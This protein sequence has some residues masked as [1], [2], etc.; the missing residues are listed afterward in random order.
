MG[1][2]RFSGIPGRR[3]RAVVL[4]DIFPKCIFISLFIIFAA[5]CF[6]LA[7]C[8]DDEIVA[9]DDG[10]GDGP[11]DPVCNDSLP[12]IEILTPPAGAETHYPARVL[13]VWRAADRG[14]IASS[15]YLLTEVEQEDDA[16]AVLNNQPE[17]FEDLWSEWEMLETEYN[18]TLIGE[19]EPLM[20]G[21]DYLFAVQVMDS[22]GQ[23]TG[24]FTHERNT[25][26]FTAVMRYP[27]LSVMGT[28]LGSGSFSGTHHR[29]APILVP[30]GVPLTFIWEAPNT[31]DWAGPIEYRY[32]WDVQNLSDD[33][34]W[35]YGWSPWRKQSFGRSFYSGVHVF[36][37]E[38][39]DDAGTITR[40]RIEIEII[41]FQMDRDLLWVDDWTLGDYMPNRMFPSETEHDEF[42]TGICSMAPGFDPVI[43]ICPADEFYTTLGDD[44]L[45]LETLSRYKHVIWTYSNSSVNVWKNTIRFE[46]EPDKAPPPWPIII[47][48][49]VFRPNTLAL[50][51]AGGGSVLT[52]GRGDLNDSA[53]G[54]TF[55]ISPDM[56][57]SVLDEYLSNGPASPT[58]N[59]I[60]PNH[61]CRQHHQKADNRQVCI[62]IGCY[63]KCN[64]DYA[65]SWKECHKKD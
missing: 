38:A 60:Q 32:G 40:A 6:I 28:M 11:D 52:C 26:Q 54:S 46:P 2:E 61:E 13:F 51:L 47:Q 35:L 55:P 8:T 65:H 53:L 62:S 36:Y 27:V 48:W 37:V 23:K 15:R 41:P 1:L 50:Y 7:G 18:G 22:C 57:A 20:H 14:M 31:F 16:I 44:P 42:W 45:P 49:P 24:V 5:A 3:A 29:P 25:R 30:P 33:D 10:N 17:L 58:G 4:D 56:P 34:E 64:T 63:Y 19:D 59:T 9:P 39:R 21:R 12:S 43:D